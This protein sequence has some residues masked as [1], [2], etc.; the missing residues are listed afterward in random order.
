MFARD[1]EKK[2]LEGNRVL[3]ELRELV[4]KA[5]VDIL[6]DVSFV[7]IL[8]VVDMNVVRLCLGL[9]RPDQEKSYKTVQGI[10]HDACILLGLESPWAASAEANDDGN[11]SSQGAVQRM[12]ELNP[13][14]SLRNAQDLLS[15][16]GF[17]LGVCIRK[18]GEKFEGQITGLDSSSVT[19]KDLKSGGVLKVQAKDM[20][21][22]GW[23]IFKPKAEPES[24]ESLQCMGPKTNADFM[25]GLLIAQIH[26]TMHELVS[27]HKSHET[28]GGLSVKPCRGLVRQEVYGK[29]KL[30]LVPYSWKVI[31]RTPK[32]EPMPNA[33][34]VQTK[35]KADDREFWI[36]SC[37]H[38]PKDGTPEVQKDFVSPYF[39]VTSCEDEDS[40]NMIQILSGNAQASI[41]IPLLKNTKEIA[42]GTFLHTLKV[43]AQSAEDHET[44]PKAKKAKTTKK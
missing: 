19:V 31:T 10:A 42:I 33:V 40:A 32:P 36:V 26:Q 16:Q 3:S 43:K 13:D 4:A 18:K 35:W 17:V 22:A 7:N 15:D 30:I 41:R 11:S 23:T 34:Q 24:I 2:V 29:N 9:P 25:A 21:Y 5:G 1:C 27:T 20:L 37:K 6:Q 38:L 12:R 8:A 28:L 14:G 39:L 44:A